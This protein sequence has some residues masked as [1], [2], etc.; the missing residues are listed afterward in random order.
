M[1]GRTVALWPSNIRLDS[2]K[3]FGRW[4]GVV[5]SLSYFG[6]LF[7]EVEARCLTVTIVFWG[8]PGSMRYASHFRNPFIR[9]ISY[10]FWI[11]HILVRLCGILLK[12]EYFCDWK[13]Y[14]WLECHENVWY[15]DRVNLA[16]SLA[17][18]GKPGRLGEAGEEGHWS[19]TEEDRV[20]GPLR[21]V[22]SD[23]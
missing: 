12:V 7:V 8:N 15:D 21:F 13:W 3:W 22:K 6:V 17:D 23:W 11:S 10:S 1:E 19:C 14:F 16:N 20:W 2:R 5:R 9:I 4:W 18:P